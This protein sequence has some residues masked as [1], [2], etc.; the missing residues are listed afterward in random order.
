MGD[1][2]ASGTVQEAAIEAALPIVD[3][4]QHFWD[5]HLRTASC[6]V[7]VPQYG[8]PELLQDLGTGHRIVATG[9]VESFSFYRSH[10][11]H[12]CRSVGETENAEQLARR[13]PGIAAAIVAHADLRQG[14]AVEE[15]LAAHLQASHRVRA[16]RQSAAWHSDPRLQ[17][18]LLADSVRSQMLAD[19]SF[20][21]AAA[22]VAAFGL[23]F[24][25][26]LYHSQIHELV[27]LAR[28]LPDLT[29]ILDHAGGPVAPHCA[30]ANDVFA[31]WL[32]GI[33]DLAPC[34]NV[35]LKL[36]GL[37]M[38]STPLG[39]ATSRWHCS[40]AL[41]TALQPW[42]RAAIDAFSPA[43]CLFEGNFPV[44]KR[45]CSYGILWNAFK[46]AT[47][48]YTQAERRRMFGLNAAAL[49][50]IRLAP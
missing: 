36:G 4:H 26:F 3:A 20:R 46:R 17:I 19:S 35:W 22:R 32:S 33:R 21:A 13:S 12:A 44:E 14:A 25:T 23:S 40:E 9:A 39:S 16:I 29:I 49:Y 34:P 28:A 31:N 42:L 38:A 5:G 30:H 41:A 24:E 15:V 47:F 18:A 11:P 2:A 43:R 10:G 7:A 50:R 37:T 1:E 6:R 45:T 8:L 48:E 27:A